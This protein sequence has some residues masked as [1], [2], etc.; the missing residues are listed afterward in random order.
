MKKSFVPPAAFLVLIASICISSWGASYSTAYVR[1]SL[2]TTICGCSY[3]EFTAIPADTPHISYG[4]A[5]GGG[6]RINGETQREPSYDNGSDV[7]NFDEQCLDNRAKYAAWKELF[8][9]G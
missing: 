1:E 8:S 3:D 5:F 9:L 2:D 6:V 4:E 7:S